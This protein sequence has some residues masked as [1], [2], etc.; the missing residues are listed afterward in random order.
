MEY[1]RVAAKWWADK[2]RNVGSDNFNSGDAS[3]TGRLVAIPATIA[4]KK[5]K[6]S[7]RAIKK[8]EKELADIIKKYVENYGSITLSV[9]YKP[10]FILEGLAEQAGIKTSGFPW[11]TTMQ[12]KKNKVIVRTGY[13]KPAKTIFPKS[14][15]Y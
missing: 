11:K 8:F 14:N 5:A 13:A 1:N 3:Y 9:D 6:P 15:K 10:D 7:R 12:I 2:I 4:A